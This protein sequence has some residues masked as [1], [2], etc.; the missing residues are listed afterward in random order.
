MQ[1]AARL[2]AE[3]CPQLAR[4]RALTAFGQG[5]DNTVF[6]LGDDLLVRLPQRDLGGVLMEA[7]QRVLPLTER[8]LAA[9]GVD[10]GLPVPLFCGVP[11]GD[12]AW[13]FSVVPRLPGTVGYAVPVEHR[14]AGA[15]GLARALVALHRGGDAAAAPVNPLRNGHIADKPRPNFAVVESLAGTHLD[16]QMVADAW[17]RWSGAPRWGGPPVAVH[18]D[19]HAGN[20]LFGPLA[21]IDWGDATAGDPA[22]DLAAAWTV[23]EGEGS[24]AFVAEATALGHD[25]E[26]T[27]SRARAWALRHALLVA[28][29]PDTAMRRQAPRVLRALFS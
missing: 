27:W 4:G 13:R 7:E 12:Y 11:S 22:A 19:V 17:H 21:L 2:L 16:E 5:W 10:I 23:F 26:A 15:R 3:Q 24:A 8:V 14:A 25:D 28:E 18:G 6:A 20:V 29:G 9:A 1:I